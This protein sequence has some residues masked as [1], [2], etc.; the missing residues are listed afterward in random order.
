MLAAQVGVAERASDDNKEEE[1]GEGGDERAPLLRPTPPP[2]SSSSSSPSSQAAAS[3]QPRP[4]VGNRLV[5]KAN[6]SARNPNPNLP[7]S[8]RYRD[9]EQVLELYILSVMCLKRC[10]F[11]QEQLADSLDRD[12]AAETTALLHDN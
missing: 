2:S 5:R 10:G 1:E 7:R 8:S 9:V 12:N 11:L 6:E 4:I 3:D